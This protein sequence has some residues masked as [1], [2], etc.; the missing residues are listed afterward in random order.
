M[1]EREIARLRIGLYQVQHPQQMVQQHVQGQK[2][3][4]SKHQRRS[5]SRDINFQFSGMSLNNKETNNDEVPV[6]G[7]LHI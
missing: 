5:N 1:L 4:I 3:N 6:N 7:A 2:Q